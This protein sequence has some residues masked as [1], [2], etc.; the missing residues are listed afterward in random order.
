[1]SMLETVQRGRASKPPRILCYGVEG[2]GKSTFGAQAPNPIFI[3]TEDGLD[4]IDCN[5]F[6]LAASYDE[7]A[8]ALTDL[9]R[10]RR[11]SQDA[12]RGLP[13]GP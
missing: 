12:A 10:E 4:E 7:V 1:M 3:Q 8:A 13:P 5:R 6:P 9:R 11:R 2:I